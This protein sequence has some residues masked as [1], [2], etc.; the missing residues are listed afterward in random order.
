MRLG[1]CCRLSEDVGPVG[2]HNVSGWLL[3]VVDAFQDGGYAAGSVLLPLPLQCLCSV[4]YS[5]LLAFLLEVG[6]AD[7]C[8]L[9]DVLL[10]CMQ[11]FLK[12]SAFSF[13]D[14]NR[15]K[16]QPIVLKFGTEID[17]LYLRTEFVNGK[18]RFIMTE[19]I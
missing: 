13:S 16:S 14:D 15:S 7:G 10:E 2:F 11:I 3:G 1:V 17:L 18:N 5:R 9:V 6:G 12:I 4:A 19:N 8:R